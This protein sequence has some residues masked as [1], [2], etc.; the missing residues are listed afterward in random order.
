MAVVG[1]IL[2]FRVFSPRVTRRNTWI[3]FVF[4]IHGGDEVL[5][6]NGILKKLKAYG[7]G[8]CMSKSNMN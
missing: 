3:L 2:C 6:Y 1:I 4:I 8:C 7:L 5:Y